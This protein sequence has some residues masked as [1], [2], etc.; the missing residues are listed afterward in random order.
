MQCKTRGNW[1]F[2]GLFFDFRVISSSGGYLLKITLKIL[3]VGIFEKTKEKKDREDERIPCD[4]NS[5]AN[6]DLLCDY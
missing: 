3:R 2:S 4:Q 1:R 5:Q 6:G